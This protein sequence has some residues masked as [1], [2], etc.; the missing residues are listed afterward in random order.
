MF[1][2]F[3]FEIR[4]VYKMRLINLLFVFFYGNIC[5]VLIICRGCF[6]ELIKNLGLKFVLR[7]YFFFLGEE[8]GVGEG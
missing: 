8:E 2:Y 3:I 4:I 6:T 1:E 7:F 5:L